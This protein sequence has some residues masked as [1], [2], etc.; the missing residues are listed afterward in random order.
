MSKK[1][2]PSLTRFSD[3]QLR[4]LHIAIVKAFGSPNDPLLGELLESRYRKAHRAT[5]TYQLFKYWYVRSHVWKKYQRGSIP[6][7]TRVDTALRTFSEA[8]T[9]CRESNSRLYDAFNPSTSALSLSEKRMLWRARQIVSGILGSYD[10]D[11]HFRFCDFSPGATTEFKRQNAAIPTK[12][13]EGSHITKDALPYGIAFLRVAPH[14]GRFLTIV[15][16]NEVFTVPKDFKKDRTCAKEPTLNM[17]FQKGLGGVFRNRLQREGLLHSDAAARHQRL[18]RKASIDGD[19]TTDDLSSASD[20]ICLVLPQLLLPVKWFEACYRLRSHQGT[21]PDGTVITYEKISSMGNGYTFELETLLFYA[22]IRAVCGKDTTVSV[23]GDDL[24]YPSRYCAQVRSLLRTCGFTLNKEKSFNEGPFRESCGG[25]FFKGH[26]VTPFYLHTMPTT[27]GQ[28][29]DL[30]NN[31]LSYH[32]N[33]RP[34]PRLV[35]VLKEC[36]K[37]IPRKFWGPPGL[38]GVLWAEWDEARPYLVRR[39]Q[40]YAVNAVVRVVAE[41]RHDYFLG[42]L[43]QTLW[44]GP[45]EQRAMS[46]DAQRPHANKFGFHPRVLR[47]VALSYRKVQNIEHSWVNVPIQRE[48]IERRLIGTNQWTT[49]LPVFIDRD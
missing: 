37:L 36:R 16:G 30:H 31:I 5:E 28:I 13:E 49:R 15:D 2:E 40:T 24:I 43:Y 17:F 10:L 27:Y 29:I 47:K 22:L 33:M 34:S 38:S 48:K 11:E 18:A 45:A 19:L 20:T 35:R 32:D 25:H 1:A 26:D 42:S 14:H 9:K 12:W 4:N 3:M 7:S 21:L 46:T 39:F 44:D 23:Y 8:E 41:Q 6:A